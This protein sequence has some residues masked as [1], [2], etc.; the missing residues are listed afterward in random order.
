MLLAALLALRPPRRNLHARGDAGH[1]PRLSPATRPSSRSPS[2]SPAS[3]F[4]ICCSSR[5]WRCRAG[6]LNSVD[7]FAA[8]AATPILLN[9]FLIAALL[10]MRRFG[11]HDGRAL[12][13]AVTAAGLAQFLW[14]MFSCARAGLALRLPLAAAD[15]AGAPHAGDHGAGRA[16]RRGHPGQPADLDRARLVAAGRLGLV[17]LLRR[18]AEPAAARRR[19]HRRRHRDPAALVAPVAAS[20]TMPARSRRRIAGS[21]WPCC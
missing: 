5:W 10:L 7:R 8:A 6:V 15:A 19:R 4:P 12:A 2:P 20:A 17:S 21:S 3:P 13:W 9:L 18:P 16:R 1:R 14:L 11:W